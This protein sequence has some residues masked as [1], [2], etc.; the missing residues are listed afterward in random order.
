MGHCPAHDSNT[1]KVQGDD[2]AVAKFH[3]ASLLVSSKHGLPGYGGH[4]PQSIFNDHGKPLCPEPGLSTTG[5]FN[6]YVNDDTIEKGMN[7]RDQA[8]S[9]ELKAFFTTGDGVAGQDCDMYFVQFRPMEGL[10]KAGSACESRWISDEQ[11]RRNHI[12]TGGQ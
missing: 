4:Q 8:K 6:K 9:N 12:S 10:M 3:K 1:K 2:D 7:T 5:T 11:L